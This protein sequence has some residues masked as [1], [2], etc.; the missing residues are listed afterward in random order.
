MAADPPVIG[1]VGDVAPLHVPGAATVDVCLP[2]VA[3][4]IA[5]ELRTGRYQLP[6]AARLVLD[7]VVPGTRLLDLGAHLGT[8]ALSAAARGARVVAVE[9]S[10]RNATCLAA[11][12][13]RNDFGTLA[14]ENVA[15]GDREG[16]ARFHEEGPYGRVATDDDTEAVEV[17]MRQAASIVAAHGWDG[18]DL[19]KIDVEGYELAV[20]E[21]LRPLL[22]VVAPPPVVFEVNRHV[23]DARGIETADVVGAFTQLGYHTYFVGDGVLRPASAE[24]FQ[25][26]TVADYLAIAPGRALPWPVQPAATTDELAGRVASEASSPLPEARTALARAL[27]LAPR[28]LLAHRDVER[29]LE[30]LTVDGDPAVAQA[31]SWWPAWRQA[32]AARNG[33]LDAIADGWRALADAARALTR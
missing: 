22:R 26:E 8:V 19:V 6:A 21:G 4:T 15:V 23:L 27:A 17:P 1:V 13:R 20:L 31:A 30:A 16:S 2:V 14:V 24:A 33:P 3:D 25:P 12:A 5:H 29:A 11:S 7:L 9:A 10:P 28:A 18:V 32:R